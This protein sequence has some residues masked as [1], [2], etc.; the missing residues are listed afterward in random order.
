MIAAC[1]AQ[2]GDEMDAPPSLVVSDGARDTAAETDEDGM[3]ARPAPLTGDWVAVND[4]EG[5]LRIGESRVDFLDGGTV[6]GGGPYRFVEDC[7]DRTPVSGGEAGPADAMIVGSGAQ[8]TCYT[9]MM[10]SDGGLTIRAANADDALR[11][12]RPLEE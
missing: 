3:V 5:G 9:V 8:A 4:G 11:F 2:D 12:K 6:T 10:L 1:G 7:D